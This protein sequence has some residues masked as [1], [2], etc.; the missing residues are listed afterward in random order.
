MDTSRRS[1]RRRPLTGLA[2]VTALVTTAC[3]TAANTDAVP[4]AT[5]P[6]ATEA[7]GASTWPVVIDLNTAMATQ[8][9]ASAAALTAPG[10]AA[11]KY[12]EYRSDV[13]A[14][15][16]AA[17]AEAAPDGVVVED[18]QAGTVTV[19]IGSGTDEVIYVWSGFEVDEAGLVTGWSTE[20]GRLDSL[21]S[22]PGSQAEAAGATVSVRSAYRTNEGDLLVVVGVEAEEMV[23][24]DDSVVVRLDDDSTVASAA[25]VSPSEMDAGRSGVVVY[26]FGDVP[27]GG[28]LVYEV[29]N[30]YDAPAA[31]ELP[32]I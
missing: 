20:Q 29:Q 7:T 31:V 4:S 16:D 21:I 14:A 26:R 5:T 12:V 25:T 1:S 3:G 2:I 22:S 10:S 30:S 6:E 9:F 11:Q 32:L 23:T 19:T 17:G 13:A 15:Q 8:D 24:V 28:V 27:L 18:E